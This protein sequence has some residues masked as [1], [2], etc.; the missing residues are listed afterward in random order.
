MAFNTRVLAAVM[1]GGAPPSQWSSNC[2]DCF[3]DCSALCEALYCPCLMLGYLARNTRPD[4]LSAP[5]S[6]DCGVCCM[7]CMMSYFVGPC[8]MGIFSH[9]V[10]TQARLL[11]NIQSQADECSECMIGFCCCPCSTSQVSRELTARRMHDG[12]MCVSRNRQPTPNA[13]GGAAVIQMQQIVPQHHQQPQQQQQ[14]MGGYHAQVQQMQQQYA[15]QPGM[16]Q[17]A[18]MMFAAPPQ[19]PMMYGQQ[20]PPGYGGA[21]AA[22]SYNGF[23]PQ[24]PAFSGYA[25]PQPAPM[26][27]GPAPDVL[28]PPSFRGA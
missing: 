22:Q 26:F 8:G 11:F 18:T 1:S 21:P 4:G 17:P 12:T 27:G 25:Q 14:P 9:Q 5:G 24:P 10:R 3:S 15:M 7:S 19:Q 28:P 16:G 13:M 2:T 6:C 20:P 23:S